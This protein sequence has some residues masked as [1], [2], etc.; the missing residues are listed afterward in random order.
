MPKCSAKCMF[1]NLPLN[2]APHFCPICQ[3]CFHV[4]C[5][6]T[7]Y[8]KADKLGLTFVNSI[9]CPMCA[10]TKPHLG[11]PGSPILTD[12]PEPAQRQY[13]MDDI[14]GAQFDDKIVRLSR[15]MQLPGRSRRKMC[16]SHAHLKDFGSNESETI[17]QT[18]LKLKFHIS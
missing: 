16:Q 4:I 15:R 1:E 6:N 8:V 17:C 10:S 11:Q 5:S 9:L 7:K 3:K 12:S 2:N 14:P 18:I 13:L